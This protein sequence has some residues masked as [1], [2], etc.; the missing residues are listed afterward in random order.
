MDK[1]RLLWLKT[2]DFFTGRLKKAYA[3]VGTRTPALIIYTTGEPKPGHDLTCETVQAHCKSIASY[4]RPLHMEIWP[5]GEEFPLTRSTK[6]DK[7]RLMEKAATIIVCY[8]GRKNLPNRSDR[9][10][11]HCRHG[12]YQRNFQKGILG[13]L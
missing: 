2:V 3:R 5:A 10:T 13:H 11:S 7:I 12:Q 6:V 9:G 4:K 8:P 1:K